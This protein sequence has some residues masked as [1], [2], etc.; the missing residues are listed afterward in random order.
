MEAVC[1]VL[2]TGDKKHFAP[3]YDR[4]IHGVHIL[5]PAMLAAK[6]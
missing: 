3:L 4:V 6:L 2:V 5:S 1:D